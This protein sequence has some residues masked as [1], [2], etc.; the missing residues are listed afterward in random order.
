MSHEESVTTQNS[1]SRLSAPAVLAG[2]TSVCLLPYLAVILFPAQF[3]HTL[4][5]VSYLLFHNIAEFF[6]IMVSLSIFGVGW[7][8]YSQSKNRHALFLSAAFLTIGLLDFMHTLGNAAMPPFVTPNSSNKSTQYWIAARLFSAAAFL[9]S[10]YI[11]PGR[12]PEWMPKALFSRPA[13]MAVVLAVPSVIFVG[14]TFFPSY[15]PDT[16]V[17]GIGLTR[18]KVLSEYLIILLLCLAAIAYWRRM[19]QTGDRLLIYYVAAFVICI[20]SELV[21][22]GYKSAFDTYNVLGHLYKIAAFFLIYQGI[23]VAS[24]RNPYIGLSEANRRLDIEIAERSQAEEALR[25]A[26]EELELSHL[27]LRQAYD[28]LSDETRQREQVELQLRQTQKMEALGTLTGGIAHD[29]N[30][31]LAAI[32]GFTEMAAEDVPKESLTARSLQR[33]LQAGIRARDL[34]KQ[35]LTFS[36]RTET[37]K[38]PLQLKNL[39]KETITLIRASIPTT[40]SIRV[41]LAG[42]SALVSADPTQIQQVVMNLCTNAAHAIGAHGGVL[43][44]ELHECVPSPGE[45]PGMKPG[46][47]VKLVV[48]DTGAGIAP[49]HIDRIFDPFFTTKKAGEGTGLGLSVVHGIVHQHGGHI[50]VQSEP[51]KGTLFSVYFPK[52]VEEPSGMGPSD[53][54]VPRG[55]ERILFVDDEEMLVE[56]GKGLLERLGYDVVSTTSPH[57]AL[58]I[59]SNDPGRFDLV[60]TDQTM[61]D[62]TGVELSQKLLGL[63]PDIPIILCTGFSHLVDAEA[64]QKAGVKGFVM[65]PLSKQ[66]IAQAIRKVL[67]G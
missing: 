47:Y 12:K 15:V 19:T 46:P 26:K 25:K 8:T 40:I 29:F 53:E 55:Q 14:I 58:S 21:F 35:M 3:Q 65:K 59:F 36:R 63:R 64:A 32:I 41:N 45:V 24:V 51:G 42:D 66:E 37:E 20:F 43:H 6:S 52:I 49:E 16:Y 28:K 34:I 17:T 67:E 54:T 9:I 23:F 31:I 56:M 39:V 1:F 2:T 22:T 62:M 38:K 27:E 44:V 7:Y 10:A 11:Y 18:F 33:V 50:T 57:D 30:N 4:D 60:V 48:R 13:L 5:R 61:P